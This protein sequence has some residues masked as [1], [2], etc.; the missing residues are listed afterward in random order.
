MTSTLYVGGSAYISGRIEGKIELDAVVASVSG[1]LAVTAKASLDGHA[2]STVTLHY[3]KGKF[4]ADANFELLAALALT[5]AL[6]A[7]VE[8]EAG[9]WRFKVKTRKDWNL[10]SFHYDTGL[11]FGM[12]LKKPIHY[13]SDDGVKLPTFNDIEWIKPDIHPV[14]MLE[15]IFAGGGT[16]KEE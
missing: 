6:D 9:V 4:E 8:A 3:Q 1:G 10:A 2:S 13:S 11:Q 16:E 14:D 12:K 7:F 15:K 5:L